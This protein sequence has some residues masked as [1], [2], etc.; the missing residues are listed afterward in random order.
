MKRWLV[1]LCILLSFTTA[2]AREKT[3]SITTNGDIVFLSSPDTGNGSFQIEGTWTGTI[4]FEATLSSTTWVALSVTPSNSTTTVT[5]TTANGTWTYSGAYNAVRMRATATITGTATVRLVSTWAGRGGGGPTAAGGGSGTVTA[6]G[7]PLIHQIPVWTTATDIK[8]ITVGTTGQYFRGA[9][10]ADPIWSTLTLPNAGTAGD[11]FAAT[12][13]N[14][15]GVISDVAVGQL[16]ASGGVGVVPAYT[17]S[18]TVTGTMT[19]AAF[20]TS[21]VSTGTVSISG[22]TSG[23]GIL[24]V[25]SVAG[26]PTVTLGTNS[27]TPAV[28]ATGPLEITTAT[29]NIA[30]SG[31]IAPANLSQTVNAQTGTTYTIADGD[32][33][34]LVTHTNGAAIA[35][36]LPQAGGGGSFISGWFYDTQNR[37]VGTATITPTTSTIDGAATLALTTAQGVR[38][39]S[40]GTNYFTQRGIGG[41][42]GGPGTGTQF[43]IPLWA[44]TTTLGDSQITQTAA[45][46]STMTFNSGTTSTI[47]RFKQNVN[48]GAD[49]IIHQSS[50]GATASA[51][52]VFEAGVS[53][54]LWAIGQ[55]ASVL[56]D[57]TNAFGIYDVG[58]SKLVLR[59]GRTDATSILS[60]GGGTATVTTCGATP[61]G[62]VAGNNSRGVVTV[63]GG[64]VTACTLNFSGT[65]PAA[66]VCVVT[67]SAAA[68]PV[69]VT[70]ISTSALVLN[71]TLTGQT[72]YYHCDIPL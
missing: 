19:A 64:A 3:G 33:G 59:F 70:S 49:V 10:A 9:S 38:I 63:G 5:S 11:L 69:G 50:L 14:T 72:V 65:L 6:S 8:G 54:P 40:D 4:S 24:T 28:T 66:P 39:F 31:I 34:K 13:T 53:N 12:S 36:T 42:G 58:A 71:G 37:G 7:T 57:G 27:G 61:N 25:Q 41:S 45:T 21:G 67:G 29:G 15:M 43:A 52:L 26:T 2:E 47:A 32:R 23:T 30:L 16:L 56:G 20:A 51:R 17:A 22:A 35:V 68:T 60:V 55:D 48:G 1:L 44:T 46:N 62:S 18:P